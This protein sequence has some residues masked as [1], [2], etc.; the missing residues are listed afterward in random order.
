MEH[1]HDAGIIQRERGERTDLGYFDLAGSGSTRQLPRLLVPPVRPR[2]NSDVSQDSVP[3]PASSDFHSFDRRLPSEDYL[4]ENDHTFGENQ[5][6]WAQA[7]RGSQRAS[8]LSTVVPLTPTT[9]ASYVTAAGGS[10]VASDVA[11]PFPPRSSSLPL[12]TSDPV[13][14][15]TPPQEASPSPSQP[16]QRGSSSSST[17]PSSRKVVPAFMLAADRNELRGQF[18]PLGDQTFSTLVSHEEPLPS[19]SSSSSSFSS[20][21]N[22]LD[23]RDTF[24]FSYMASSSSGTLSEDG[25]SR[26][27]RRGSLAS[28]SS[29]AAQIDALENVARCLMVPQSPQIERDDD[30]EERVVLATHTTLQPTPS[31]V[32][33]LF[34]GS[35]RRNEGRRHPEVVELLEELD[36]S[37]LSPAQV[38]V[39]IV[40]DEVAEPN[41]ARRTS[42]LPRI[43]RLSTMSIG[44]LMR[45]VDHKVRA[46]ARTRGGTADA[47]RSSTQA[48]RRPL[49]RHLR[50]LPTKEC[51]YHRPVHRRH[52]RCSSSRSLSRRLAQVLQLRRIL[53][54]R[55]SQRW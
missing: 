26:R 43:N 6:P 24:P 41:T 12:A 16:E 5:A 32:R 40:V 39:D 38:H 21:V 20:P 13:Y 27:R 30:N 4:I 53:P 28:L 48:T 15:L 50:L 49:P 55:Q 29:S 25:M 35:M 22:A 54:L 37:S 11:R 2:W 19:L 47:V 18:M 8:E 36:E 7:M 46:S 10:Q 51:V 17:S 45:R 23:S 31:L 34:S 44:S 14:P 9:L 1:E 42:L 52:R 33:R 3:S